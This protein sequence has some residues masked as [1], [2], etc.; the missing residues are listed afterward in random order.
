VE[1]GPI[2]VTVFPIG[3]MLAGPLFGIS[4]SYGF[5]PVLISVRPARALS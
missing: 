5:R 1:A 3:A 4:Q 2:R